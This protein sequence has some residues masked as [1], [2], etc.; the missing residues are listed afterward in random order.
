M[1]KDGNNILKILV[2]AQPKGCGYPFNT[3]DLIFF[4]GAGFSLRNITHPEG[5][6]YQMIK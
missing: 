6:G 3:L 2:F 1:R 5:C 4:V